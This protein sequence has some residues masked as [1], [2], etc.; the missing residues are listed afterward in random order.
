M[1]LSRS[2]RHTSV[3]RQSCRDRDRRL[4]WAAWAASVAIGASIAAGSTATGQTTPPASAASHQES[5]R[6]TNGPV[7]L[8]ATLVLPRGAGRH[9]A[10]VV[11]HG[12][13]PE[14][15]ST[16]VETAEW[17]AG[18]G[19]VALIYDKR[20]AGSSTGNWQLA[21]YSVLASDALAGVE[22]LRRRPEVDT[23]A[24][25][26]WGPS[27]GGWVAPL[28]AA[29]SSA[30]KFVILKSA[31]GVTPERQ[32]TFAWTNQL[33]AAGTPDSTIAAIN[34]A[35]RAIWAYARTGTGEAAARASLVRAQRMPGYPTDPEQA[36]LVAAVPP[37]AMLNDSSLATK[38]FFVRTTSRFDP[39]PVLAQVHVPT[40][41]IFGE[42]DTDT[43]VRK[44]ASAMRAAFA[45]SGNRDLTIV[46]IPGADHYLDRPTSNGQPAMAPEYYAA[47]HQWLH[48]HVKGAGVG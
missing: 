44:S 2:T 11:L 42:G 15:R 12:S 43:P 29:R 21:S 6:I 24:I 31:I 34:A 30:V 7:T 32:M 37:A 36:G 35:R 39:G 27:E 40:L 4:S 25:G 10:I 5:L 26:V 19:L 1:S 14:T 9:P 33:R 46:M 48:T 47:M 22:L 45:R 28:A 18:Q 23:A 38:M 16:L 41:A 20:G 8:A 17:F 13:G 3:A